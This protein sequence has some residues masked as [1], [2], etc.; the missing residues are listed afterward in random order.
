MVS[1]SLQFWYLFSGS[2]GGMSRKKTRSN[3]FFHT[4]EFLTCIR[5]CFKKRTKTRT[6]PLVCHISEF[7]PMLKK[8]DSQDGV[9]PL[10]QPKPLMLKNMTKFDSRVVIYKISRAVEGYV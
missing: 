4:I 3:L 9:L 10:L 1:V 5:I 7:A 8:R 6:N 2:F